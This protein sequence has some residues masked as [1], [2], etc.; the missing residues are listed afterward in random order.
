MADLT[1]N[2]AAVSPSNQATIRREFP[3]GGAIGAGQVVYKDANGRWVLFDSDAGAGAG[4]N[5]GD[6]R[7]IALNNGANTQPAAVCTQDP[8]FGIGAT[9]ANG[10]A[11]FGSN[12]AGGIT[13]TA[14]AAANYTVFLGVAISATRINLNPTAA[15]VPV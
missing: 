1:I 3:F 15:G 8:N 6:L 2:S 11:Y 5:V 12:T 10:V 4:A 9:V 7:G 14:P 13:A